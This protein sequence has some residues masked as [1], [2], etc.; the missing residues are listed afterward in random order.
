[1][2]VTLHFPVSDARSFL[3]GAT[4]P[5]DAPSWPSPSV[6]EFVRHIGPVIPPARGNAG[7][8]S[9][10]ESWCDAKRA[11][12]FDSR[13]RLT[14][15]GRQIGPF[16]ILFRRNTTDGSA[17]SRFE[18][19]FGVNSDY[20]YFGD[21][22]GPAI[23]A[24]IRSILQ[25]PVRIAGPTG[26]V[27][28]TLGGAGKSLALL[29]RG[30]GILTGSPDPHPDWSVVGCL[31]L[32]QI[33][34]TKSEEVPRQ[35]SS[36]FSYNPDASS[37]DIE[38]LTVALGT[39][40]S[41]GGTCRVSVVR[42]RDPTVRSSEEHFS[43]EK[44]RVQTVHRA[45]AQLHYHQ[46]V[47]ANVQNHLASERLSVDAKSDEGQ[48]LQAF[49]RRSVKAIRRGQRNLHGLD[50]EA[51]PEWPEETGSIGA[52]Q[53]GSTPEDIA[54]SLSAAMDGMRPAIIREAVSIGAIH[55][56]VNGN[57]NGSMNVA[58]TAWGQGA[59]AIDARVDRSVRWNDLSHAIELTAFAR[60]IR[61]LEALLRSDPSRATSSAEVQAVGEAAERAERGD[62]DGALAVLTPVKQWLKKVASEFSCK[63]VV[64]FATQFLALSG[65]ADSL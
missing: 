58:G 11:I 36:T 62:G 26:H 31:P 21:G 3:P 17:A 22:S 23:N 15:R 9:S 47:L 20:L 25:H 48:R 45:L 57:M 16:R 30:S 37:R 28:T 10:G 46:V 51:L 53:A 56:N 32:V 6:G 63:V 40:Q 61:R 4:T 27:S 65:K 54:R 13:P 33:C 34:L 44:S 1:M 14:I 39:H 29:V 19:C 42:Y 49:V 52:D 12:R 18:L 41:A 59:G 60:D 64:D 38:S 24:A 5:C 55:I 50:E 43:Q 35:L 2:I 7:G 8:W